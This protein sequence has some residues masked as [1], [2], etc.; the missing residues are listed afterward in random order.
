MILFRVMALLWLLLPTMAHGRVSGVVPDAAGSNSLSDSITVSLLTCWPGPEVYELCGH[1]AVR[2]KGAGVDSVWNYGVFD[3]NQ[4][5]F[6]YRFVRGE[7]DYMV[8]GYPY[9]WFHDEYSARGSR[10]VEQEL[11]LTQQEAWKLRKMLQEESLPQ[12]RT[13]RYNYVRDNCATRIVDRMD[14]AFGPVRYTDTVTYSSFRSVMRHYHSHYPWYQFGIDIAL[15]LGLDHRLSSREEMFAPLLMMEKV[16]TASLPDG[17]KLVRDT[18]VANV[19]LD[20]ATLPP[21]PWYLT[22]IFCMSVV[23]IV[24]VAIAIVQCVRKRVFRPVYTVCYGI[25]GITGIVSAFLV[26]FSSH[27]ATSPNLMLV[28][29]N[30]LQLLFAACVW[31][32]KVRGVALVMAFYNIV[33]VGG[34]LLMWSLQS[35]VANPAIFPVMGATVALALSYAIITLGKSYN[36]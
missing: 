30:P 33:V 9:P 5:D 20:D 34:L 27:E 35:Q 26:F 18:R 12:N 8:M 15:G 2:I 3:F 31:W 7:T 36:N 16:S 4:S 19:G 23:F 24:C 29:L 10:V 1:E 21:T 14:S 28:L 11:N 22:P 13:Y 17:R 25:L 32:R 6:I